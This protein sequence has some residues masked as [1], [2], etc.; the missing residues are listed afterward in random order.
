V[1]EERG[2]KEEREREREKEWVKRDKER[3]KKNG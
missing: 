3:G 2:R 1:K